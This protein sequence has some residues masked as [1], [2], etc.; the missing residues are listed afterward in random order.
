[1]DVT[2]RPP[3]SGRG[4]RPIATAYGPLLDR[5]PQAQ[6]ST[7]AA[8]DLF[9][10]DTVFLRRWFVRFFIDHGTRRMHI[11]RHPTGPWITW[12]A[13]NYLMDLG[14]RAASIR[15]LIRDRGAYSTD[16]FDAVFQAI[17]VR[18]IPTLPEVPRMN[19]TAE[20]WIGS[21]RR[22]ERHL[23]LVVSEYAEHDNRHRPHRS[24]NSARRTASPDPDPVPPPTTL[25]SIDA[26]DSAASSTNPRRSHR[27]TQFPAPTGSAA[28]AAGV[29]WLSVMDHY[30][31]ME[32][33]GGAEASMLEAYT[34]LSAENVV[35]PGR[36]GCA[37][38]AGGR[39]AKSPKQALSPG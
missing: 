34:T 14:D 10:I 33:N 15:F 9:Y 31:Q 7:I 32:H 35:H 2:S 26:I 6:A 21:C 11:T 8:T 18:G 27:A 39:P 16:S 22:K 38:C 20:R 37:R 5:L 1:M 25:A 23:H 12:Q 13:R 36:R 24:S 17:G 4:D 30:S 19:A 28:E 3:P 29:K